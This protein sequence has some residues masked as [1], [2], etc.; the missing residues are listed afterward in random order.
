MLETK[1][2][3]E[4]GPASANN[5][6]K[7]DTRREVLLV[8]DLRH[9]RDGSRFLLALMP[10]A[11]TFAVL[12]ACLY[13][14]GGVKAAAAF[15][16]AVLA[17]VISVWVLIQIHRARLLGG[18]IRVSAARFPEVQALVDDVSP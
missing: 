2:R 1:E 11:A 8:K 18:A 9:P 4:A 15:V 6:D 14:L 3:G 7:A 17:V 5:A 13:A 12:P 16:G 10:S